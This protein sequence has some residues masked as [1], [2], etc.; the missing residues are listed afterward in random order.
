MNRKTKRS[1][2]VYEFLQTTGLLEHGTTDQIREAKKTYWARVRKQWKRDHRAQ[3]ASYTI[4]FSE[5]QHQLLQQYASANNT[6]IKKLLKNH[7]EQML[8]GKSVFNK[9]LIG[10]IRESL[11]LFHSE[12]EKLNIT[13]HQSG[14]VINS[15]L[16]QFTLVETTILF[17][18]INNKTASSVD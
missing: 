15:L 13:Q 17:S 12:L 16:N 18:L 8:T 3:Y 14:D 7:C 9:Q 6:S 5:K 11:M 4:F 1:S 2:G 10:K